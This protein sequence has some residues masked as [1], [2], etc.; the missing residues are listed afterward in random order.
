MFTTYQ[1]Q[2][3]SSTKDWKYQVSRHKIYKITFVLNLFEITYLNASA[4]TL[5]N[6]DLDT[7]Q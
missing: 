6:P 2:I 5:H 7:I 3:V 4:Y 1:R